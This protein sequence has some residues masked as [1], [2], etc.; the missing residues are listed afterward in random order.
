MRV[1]VIA[2]IKKDCQVLFEGKMAVYRLGSPS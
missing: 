2:L 1:D